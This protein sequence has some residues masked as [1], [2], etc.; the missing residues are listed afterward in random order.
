GRLRAPDRGWLRGAPAAAGHGAPALPPVIG[1][2]RVLYLLALALWVGEIACFSFVVAPAVFGVLGAARAGDVVAAIFP[3]YYALG[4][5]AGAVALACGIV[6]GRRAPAGG[7][8]TGTVLVLA[9]GLAATLWAGRVVHPRAGAR[10]VGAGRVAR[11]LRARAPRGERRA[12][13]GARGR[14]HRAALA[15]A[16]PPRAR[17]RRLR[18]RRAGRGGGRS[19]ARAHG[20]H[21][22]RD[23]AP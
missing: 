12:G 16:L 22:G 1:L 18:A 3:R 13:A 15:R 17:A 14:S 11:G 23:G 6:L 8:W 21:R 7:W 9:L 4:A 2:L 5:A 20:A 19:L 10:R